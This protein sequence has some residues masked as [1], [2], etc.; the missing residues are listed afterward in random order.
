MKK[1]F[2][3]AIALTFL[4]FPN[5]YATN[6][7]DPTSINIEYDDDL[8]NLFFDIKADKQ[9]YTGTKNVVYF[10]VTNNTNEKQT[11]PI[12]VFF[13][14]DVEII[15]FAEWKQLSREVPIFGI[16]DVNN[17]ILIQDLNNFVSCTNSNYFDWDAT[18]C[19]EETQEQ[20]QIA[21]G[22]EDYDGWKRSKAQ[23]WQEPNLILVPDRF[24][25]EGSLSNITIGKGE[26]K[27]FVLEFENPLNSSG[28][29]YICANQDCLDPFF[30]T[31]FTWKRQITLTGAGDNNMLRLDFN[32]STF[33]DFGNFFDSSVND[34]NSVLFSNCNE[35]TQLF[36]RL[37]YNTNDINRGFD[38]NT[39]TETTC[40]FVL[41]GNDTN[42]LNQSQENDV[43]LLWDDFIT[44]DYNTGTANW[45]G[46]NGRWTESSGTLNHITSTPAL[47]STDFGSA[48]SYSSGFLLELSLS[49]IC[50]NCHAGI[51]NN[52]DGHELVADSD[53]YEMLL[54]DGTNRL[55]IDEFINGQNAG[56]TI[57]TF[58]FEW[59]LGDEITLTRDN[60]GTFRI[61]LRYDPNNL[62]Q[63]VDTSTTTGRF[64][65]FAIGAGSESVE[66][67]AYTNKFNRSAT[68]TVGA[69]QEQ[70][71]APDINV[72]S[73][74]ATGTQI[75]GG[76]VFSITFDV[77]D[78]DSNSLLIDLNFSSSSTQGTG[79]EITNDT[80]T[81]SATIT[82]DDSDFSNS[83]NCSFSWTTPTSDANFFMLVTANDGETEAFDAG[84]NNFMIDS[85]APT[86]LTILP[87]VNFTKTSFNLDFNATIDDGV[88]SGNF[89][90]I[91][92]VFFDDVLQASLD[93]NV[94]GSSGT[95]IRSISSGV[96]EDTNV[97]VGF[98]T[99][100][101]VGNV[102]DEN[103]SQNI[104][105]TSPPISVGGTGQ[106]EIDLEINFYLGQY[107][108]LT[109]SGFTDTGSVIIGASFDVFRGNDIVI[110]DQNLTA[111]G[112]FFTFVINRKAN[113]DPFTV[114]VE[115]G[116]CSTTQ[117]VQISR[118]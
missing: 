103:I 28:E 92:R 42:S 26:T 45:N 91:T 55:R 118:I 100:D 49:N 24:N 56:A 84:D 68:F 63:L 32:A 15:W 108:Q 9:T 76:D 90:C 54:T 67:Y 34:G 51:S 86:F 62:V 82:C 46:Q 70:G 107:L 80:N 94:D 102:S 85:T 48:L 35:D 106:C 77:A 6:Y 65:Y 22:I 97:S 21:T 60:A 36:H 101:N 13:D 69:E 16:V 50:E 111:V 112:N 5:I 44:G 87:D 12:S 17:F 38:L 25:P 1:A 95:C 29:F 33:G 4:F 117:T 64:P 39:G 10:K 37:L 3:L 11:I 41:Y 99:V 78:A 75:K 73:P 40:A 83:T 71:K 31:D 53:G 72:T 27:Y 66:F 52:A 116:N 81:D 115:S 110:N 7:L 19:R 47:I 23:A 104:F 89:R 88:G 59:D 43:Y 114:I 93:L 74:N 8:S 20:V 57:Q 109:Y 61:H 30:N 105:F 113:D 96:D 79:T 14:T 18:H 58:D 98:Q 2:I